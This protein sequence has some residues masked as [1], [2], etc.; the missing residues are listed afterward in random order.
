MQVD[1]DQFLLRALHGYALHQQ[2]ALEVAH[3]R[4]P[5]EGHRQAFARRLRHVQAR[6]A[7]Q[8]AF[9]LSQRRPGKGHKIAFEVV[10]HGHV[11]RQAMTVGIGLIDIIAA[12]RIKVHLL[13]KVDVRVLTRQL[14]EDAVHVLPDDLL[15]FR[16]HH[17][18][19]VHKKILIAAQPAVAGVEGEHIQPLAHAYVV[20]AR[21]LSYLQ[22]LDVVR[23]VLC[24][25]QITRQPAGRQHQNQHNQ[26][27][28]LDDFHIPSSPL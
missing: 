3:A 9:H 14:A 17:A 7:H 26:Q 22:Q 15:A 23:P 19:A 21:G 20:A 8:A 10:G 12:V 4:G 28:R 18:A 2:A 11:Q 6:E 13:E 16:T 25:R 5:G 1:D 24:K 27:Q